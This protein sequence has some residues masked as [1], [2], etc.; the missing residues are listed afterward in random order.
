LLSFRSAQEI[1]P[2]AARIAAAE[3]AAGIGPIIPASASASAGI[4]EA[5][6]ALEALEG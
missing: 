1:G 2:V 4:R 5:L 6:E 3:R